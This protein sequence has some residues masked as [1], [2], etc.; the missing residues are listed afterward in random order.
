VW[1]VVGNQISGFCGTYYELQRKERNCGSFTVNQRRK[2]GDR[3]IGFIR[4][5]SRRGEWSETVNIGDRKGW[6]F[7]CEVRR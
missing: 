4:W 1:V 5:D 7:L 2:K 3:W 6:L